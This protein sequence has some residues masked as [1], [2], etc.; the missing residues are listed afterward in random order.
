[1]GRG[2]LMSCDKQNCKV[3]GAEPKRCPGFTRPGHRLDSAPATYFSSHD[4]RIPVPREVKNRFALG[5]DSAI[6]GVGGNLH[7]LVSWPWRS[8][9]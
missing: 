7:A 4:I 2:S 3:A 1:M 8:P 5:H 6:V 9:V